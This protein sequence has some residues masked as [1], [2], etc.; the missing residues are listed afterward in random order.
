V[1][2]PILGLVG[3]TPKEGNVKR[4]LVV[5]AIA[6]LAVTLALP[7]GAEGHTLSVRK[8]K[9]VLYAYAESENA[10]QFR[11]RYCRRRSRH[12]VRCG[13]KEIFREPLLDLRDSYERT[14]YY[15]M[16]VKLR[17]THASRSS[18][19]LIYDDI[20]NRWVAWSGR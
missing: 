13:V 7:V 18:R 9:R 10:L 5:A 3:H 19:V 20:E 16:A 11:V 8:A 12:H 14:E 6:V 4:S 17:G 1:R 2:T 15:P